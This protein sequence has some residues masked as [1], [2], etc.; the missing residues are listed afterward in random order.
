M[1]NKI[2]NNTLHSKEPSI[3]LSYEILENPTERLTYP[4]P[5]MGYEEK[6]LMEADLLANQINYT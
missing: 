4:D 2:Q 1:K 5:G 3:S 6:V